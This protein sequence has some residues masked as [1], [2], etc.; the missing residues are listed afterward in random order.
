MNILYLCDEYPPCQHGGIGSA[1]Q[2]LARTLVSKGHK[3]VVAGFY[4]YYRMA[5]VEENDH[6]VK[7]Y[8]FFYGSRL[9]LQLSKRNFFGRFINIDQQFNKYIVF[10]RKI[11]QKDQISII[12]TPDF[13]EAFR[14][15]GPRIIRFP[16]FGIPM[17]VKLHSSYTVLNA[18]N[19]KSNSNKTIFIKEQ[20][21][22]DSAKGIVGVSENIKQRV[23]SIF[24][25]VREVEVLHN[26]ISLNQKVIYNTKSNFN[27]VVFAG[28]LVENK[29]VFSLIRAWNEVLEIVSTACLVLYGK[30]DAKSL[31]KI[32]SQIKDFPG[33][34]VVLK[35]FISKELL[36]EIYASASCAIFPSYHEAFSM[37]PMEAMAVGCPV[38]YTKR[39]SGP[40]LITNGVDG[41]LVDPDDIHGITNAILFMLK[42]RVR[43]IELGNNGYL[44]IKN[45]FDISIIADRHVV[46]YQGILKKNLHVTNKHN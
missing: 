44:R 36:P 16:D 37:A 25:I 31:E 6:G 26:G 8:R 43:A 15:S 10:L 13:V 28:T 46:Y 17:V 22:L 33:N 32:H 4:P 9:Q 2:L 29:G 45:H 5:H 20:Y 23:K 11:I 40:E 24:K 42:N 41:L 21:L 14:Y 38:I 35:G 18:Q 19:K 3:V 39:T 27:R 7:I 30:A 12:E 1:T 34:S